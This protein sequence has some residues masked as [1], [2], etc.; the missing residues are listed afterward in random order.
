M[1]IVTQTVTKSVTV[2]AAF[3]QEIKEANGDLLRTQRLVR[4]MCSRG[5]SLHDDATRLV[6][7]LSHLRDELAMYFSLEEAYGYFEDPLEATPWLVE[8]A[9][10]LRAEH[11][12]LYCQFIGIVDR[13]ED[14]LYQRRFAQLQNDVP[15]AF[16]VFDDQ[17]REHER[18]EAELILA[19]FDDDIGVGD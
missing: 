2:N 6:E 7:L 4:D 1:A 15:L 16:S 18:R 3:L 13:A 5:F 17:F 14:L 9:Q 12:S 10:E 19:A 11:T 8:S